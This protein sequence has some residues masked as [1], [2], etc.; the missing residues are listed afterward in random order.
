[1]RNSSKNQYI[2]NKYANVEEMLK[3]MNGCNR[4]VER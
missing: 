2:I 4:T 3:D 1:M